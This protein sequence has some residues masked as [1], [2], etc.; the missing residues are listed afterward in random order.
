[1]KLATILSVLPMAF[2]LPTSSGHAKRSNGAFTVMSARSASHIH[3]LP[4]NAAGSYFYLGG[5]ASTYCPE[6]VSKVAPCPKG[7]MTAFVGT[8]AALDVSVPGGQA[9]YVDSNGALRFTTP[10][11]GYMGE[12]ASTGPFEYKPAPSPSGIDHWVYK[13]QGASGFMACPTDD[14]KWQVFASLQNATVPQGDVS[15]CL[16]FSAMATQTQ[17]N[18]T[19]AWEY[20]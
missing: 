18:A 10:H 15:K 13:G 3:L 17:Q 5:E 11:S 19:A 12:G 1:M 9:V 2:A 14:N 4:V 6:T 8:G 7:D 20:I 16:G